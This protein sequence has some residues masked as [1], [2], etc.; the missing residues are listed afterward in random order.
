MPNIVHV[1]LS[2]TFNKQREIVNQLIDY[3]NSNPTIIPGNG[4]S[5]QS[6]GLMAVKTAGDGL[7]FDTNGNLVGNDSYPNILTQVVFDKNTPVPTPTEITSTTITFPAFN[8]IFDDQ[9]YYGKKIA[10]FNKVSVPT[11]V[12]TVDTGEDGA[13]FV[14]VDNQGEIHQSLNKITPG[15]SSTQCLL[16]SYFRLN[17]QIQSGSWAY[18]PWNGSTSKDT[19]FGGNGSLSGGLL[20]SVTA[21]TLSR[22]A[23]SVLLEGVNASTSIYMPNNK[24]Y[25]AKNPYITKKMWPGYDASDVE[26][27]TFDTTHIYNITDETVDDISEIPGF[28]VLIPDRYLIVLKKQKAQ[29]MV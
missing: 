8:V 19:R 3:A 14:Y 16:G 24:E 21:N 13:V 29:Y 5:K 17:N 18:T 11:T 28:I 27:S 23:I 7:S 12:M 9:V 26:S 6:S 4:L 25:A 22:G 10:D 15:N 20:R 1:E 2:D